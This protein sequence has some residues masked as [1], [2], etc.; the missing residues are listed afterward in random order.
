MTHDAASLLDLWAL[1]QGRGHGAR[2][3][4]LL[5]EGAGA[6]TLGARDAALLRLRQRLFGETIAAL[7]DC[8][9]CDARSEVSL[10][11]AA[12][13]GE[14]A[15][16]GQA[17]GAFTLNADGFA[18]R[19]RPL[20]ADDIP[21]LEAARD[22]VRI[23][24][25]LLRRCV[26]DAAHD[27]EAVPV[28]ALPDRVREA[29]AAA[30]LAADP[31]AELLLDLSCPECAAEWQVPLEPAA[32]LWRELDSWALRTMEEIHRLA[33]AHGWSERD[34]LAIPPARRAVYLALA[35]P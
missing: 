2:A 3:M 14:V 1:G 17:P 29:V 4:L 18:L 20:R 35:A 10:P 19:C 13:E 6:L 34:C 31:C 16:A 30:V 21:A 33:V 24:E 22:P 27:G 15:C 9:Q 11:H 12:L 28:A 8:P 25:V 23:G 5:G 7:A 26:L 32:F